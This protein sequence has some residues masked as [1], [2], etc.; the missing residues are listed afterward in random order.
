MDVILREGGRRHP[1]SSNGLRSASRSRREIQAVYRPRPARRGR[2]HAQKNE[3]QA[4]HL[5]HH[6]FSL[7]T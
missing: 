5:V 6:A 4:E 2:G 1:L 7:R 3:P